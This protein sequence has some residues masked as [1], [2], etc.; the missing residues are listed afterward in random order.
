MENHFKL[1]HIIKSQVFINMYAC[2]IMKLTKT[3]ESN[4]M[5]HEEIIPQDRVGAEGKR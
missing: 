3:H 4:K 5:N 1:N 2:G